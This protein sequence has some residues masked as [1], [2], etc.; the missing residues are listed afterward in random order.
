MGADGNIYSIEASASKGVHLVGLTPQALSGSLAP[1]KILD[2]QVSTSDGCFGYSI[3]AYRTGIVLFNRKGSSNIASFYTYSGKLL[4]G[5][6]SLGFAT[7]VNYYGQLLSYEYTDSTF[8][9][10]V[11]SE[12]DPSSRRVVWKAS[13]DAFLGPNVD[14][15]DMKPMP[16]GGAILSV[17]YPDT[18]SWTLV[19]L[20]NLGKKVWERKLSN[21]L[22]INDRTGPDISVGTTGNIAA[23]YESNVATD[24]PSHPSNAI[25]IQVH[26]TS[27]TLVY[28]QSIKGNVDSSAGAVTG[29]S[30][31]MGMSWPVWNNTLFIRVRHDP[32]Q[33][34]K[35]FAVKVPAFGRDYPLG[36]LLEK[37]PPVTSPYVALGDSFS[38]GEG[39]EPF[40]TGTNIKGTNECH[41]S[42]Y[43][44]S[45][46]ISGTSSKIPSLGSYGFRACSGAVT[47]NLTDKPQANEGVQ[48]DPWSDPS[49][50]L[51]TLTIGGNDI[52][53][54]DLAKA[55]IFDSCAKTS[56]VYK[57]SLNKINTELPGKLTTTYKKILKYAPNAK[58]YVVGY[59]QVIANK[60]TGDDFD[61][62]CFY[63][64]DQAN[65]TARTWSDVDAAR[66]I[67]TELDKKISAAV[68]SVRGLSAS[69]KRLVY[70]PVDGPTSPFNG[71]EICGTKTSWFQNLDQ[72]QN[73]QNYVFHPNKLGQELGY[74]AV[75]KAAINAG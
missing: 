30:A 44:Y 18:S 21:P 71:H 12:Y 6:R 29:Y 75:V 54:G 17:W 66:S 10:K 39:V 69:N 37:L 59:P 51:V 26:D 49:I 28:N 31:Y 9:T 5:T 11:V 62:R 47:S 34:W 32:D 8:T 58:V 43:A 19:R 45:R 57:A 63:M 42:K 50:R 27:G 33:S 67:V 73:N 1:V 4:E 24:D 38:A 46:L 15:D 70:V 48:I 64:Y 41:R 55:C 53:F 3:Q 36:A 14:I 74:A 68:N 52:G 2:V 60:K 22:P 20:S 72:A 23:I 61:G 65:P 35:L 16:D 13:S 56:N 7:S 40:E 25:T